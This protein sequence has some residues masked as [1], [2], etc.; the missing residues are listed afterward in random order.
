MR[1]RFVGI[2]AGLDLVR[3]LGRAFAVRGSA[4]LVTTLQPV[5]VVAR[6]RTGKIVDRQDLSRVGAALLLGIDY[7]FE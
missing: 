6:D 3:A 5:T 4:A 1:L 2:S 7:R